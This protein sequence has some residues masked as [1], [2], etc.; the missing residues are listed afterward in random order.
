MTM[1]S[2]TLLAGVAAAAL[3]ACA[4]QEKDEPKA[5]QGASVQPMVEAETASCGPLHASAQITL[6]EENQPAFGA[7]GGGGQTPNG[8][9]ISGID[10][11]A[12]GNID[13]SWFP[14]GVNVKVTIQIDQKAAAA[15]YRF[16]S[17][18]WQ[19]IGMA[20]VPP[21]STTSPIPR[22]GREYWND[23]EFTWPS[24]VDNGLAVTFVDKDDDCQVY[25]YGVQLVQP[26][27]GL[28][29]LDPRVQNGGVGNR[30][31]GPGC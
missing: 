1:I 29:D 13:L 9:C 27:G 14:P 10:L 3:G 16:P 7:A 17:D 12:K 24:V 25:E 20:V 5:A 26:G 8:G 28:V 15:G 4:Y 30:Q 23:S 22:Y 21:N 18:P 2:R 31:R 19:A 6:D 11:L